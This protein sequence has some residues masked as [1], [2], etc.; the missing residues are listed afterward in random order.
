MK[1]IEL[2]AESA[3]S[4]AR[5]IV[6]IASGVAATMGWK[7]DANLWLN[8]ALSV[9]AVVILVR[10]IW[11]KNQP[12]TK[13][14]QEAQNVLSHIKVSDYSKAGYDEAVKKLQAAAVAQE[15]ENHE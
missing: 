9:L 5:L 8:I 4:L 11:W 12:I 7:F 10:F 6:M 3:Y 2:N 1:N 15:A 13:A 14:A